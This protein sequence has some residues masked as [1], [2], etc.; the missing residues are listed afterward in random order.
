MFT[1]PIHSSSE[2]ELFET[3]DPGGT[4][5][6]SGL[7]HYL[8]TFV[9]DRV[10]GQEVRLEL[11]CAGGM[12]IARFEQAYRAYIDA[13]I[14]RCRSKRAGLIAHALCLLAIGVAFVFVGLACAEILSPVPSAIVSTVGSFSIWEASSIWIVEM[15]ELRKREHVLDIYRRADVVLVDE[16]KQHGR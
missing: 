4:R 5:L 3:F 12:D 10:A 2:S 15:P 1:V 7:K 14:K 9:E 16:G 11:S 6:S 8:E 13:L